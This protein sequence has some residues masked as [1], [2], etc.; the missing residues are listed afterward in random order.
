MSAS[1]AA[2]TRVDQ[3][4]LTQGVRQ[5]LTHTGMAEDAAARAAEALV[6]ADAAGVRTHGTRLLPRY[7]D[8][9]RVR[10]TNPGA[11]WR[12]RQNGV[13]LEVDAD[14]GLGQSAM[15]Q[16]LDA[17][18][19]VADR[20]GVCVA[21]VRR[22]NHVGYLGFFG[23]QAASRG[24]LAFLTQ[25]TRANM[26]AAPGQASLLGNNPF[27]LALPDPAGDPVV[28]DIACSISARSDIEQA[29][30]NGK[31]IPEGWAISQEGGPTQDPQAALAGALLP[32]GGHKGAGL[33]LILGVL[34]G[35]LSGASFGSSIVSTQDHSVERNLGHF[36][37]LIDPR[38]LLPAEDYAKRLAAYLEPFRTPQEGAFRVPGARAARASRDSAERGVLMLLTDLGALAVCADSIGADPTPFDTPDVRP[39]GGGDYTP[40]QG[41]NS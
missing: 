33:S 23:Q 36:L 37:M 26:A 5:V 32:F 4:L 14:N 6:G 28:L 39:V 7:V 2:A 22:S 16:T 24:Y 3:G 1:P 12:G 19:A 30:V 21:T 9:L 40:P 35:V 10:A 38:A 18:S 29:A 27:C 31:L 17:A 34:S 11:V 8:R 41:A 20:L 15:A 13:F 25:N